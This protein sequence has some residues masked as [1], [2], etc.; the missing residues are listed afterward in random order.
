MALAGVHS[1]DHFALNL[2]DLAGAERFISTVGISVERID[3]ELRLRAA[4]SDHVW[5]RVFGG[6]QKSLAYLSL[7]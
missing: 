7:V 5:G 2:P 3:E 1:I 6:L 4:G